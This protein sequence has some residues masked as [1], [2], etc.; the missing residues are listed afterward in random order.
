MKLSS[1]HALVIDRQ[2]G[3]LS[4]EAIELLDLH[5]AQHAEARAEAERILQT[6]HIT[7]EAVVRHPELGRVAPLA[8]GPAAAAPT[9]SL[10]RSRFVSLTWLARAAAMVLL[11][12]VTTAGGFLAGRSS[13]P[14][15]VQNQKP[16]ASSRAITLAQANPRQSSPW[17]QYRMSVDPSGE[18][19]QVQR[20][21]LLNP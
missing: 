8:V 21:D 20:V 6:L 14:A 11:V 7:R 9:L 10:K 15:M 1:L 12:A 3:E 13:V 5:L 4:P 18:G 17:A 19:V 16:A 2:C